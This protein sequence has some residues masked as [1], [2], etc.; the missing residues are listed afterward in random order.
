MPEHPPRFSALARPLDPSWPTNRAILALM[1]IGA[2]VAAA[3]RLGGGTTGAG[4]LAWAAV[5]GAAVVLGTWALGREL[6]PDDQR[7]AFVA[8]ALG[9]PAALVVEGSSLA[10]L[11][12]AM[13]LARMVARTVGPPPTVADGLALVGLVGWAAIS[14]SEPDIWL[15]AAFAFGV[16][17]AL[18]GG[19]RRAWLFAA[20]VVALAGAQLL[21]LPRLWPELAGAAGG[22]STALADVV[23]PMPMGAVFVASIVRT[24]TVAS[25][26]DETNRPLSARR[27]R[28][29]MG[30][31]LLLAARSLLHGADGVAAATPVWT[32]LAGV[33]LSDLVPGGA[34]KPTPTRGPPGCWT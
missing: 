27:V 16:D 26:A 5:F 7:A 23:W 19:R 13:L 15:V 28:W 25:V 24:R 11:F 34:G 2:A 30:V 14:L 17:A 10:L 22:D 3:V 4:P 31:A 21:W 29:G 33:A 8:L 18:E 32:V 20:A 9:Y 6:A 12:S 1:P